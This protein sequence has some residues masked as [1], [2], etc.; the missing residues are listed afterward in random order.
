MASPYSDGGRERVAS[1]L[2]VALRQKLVTRA[3]QLGI[4]M[5]DAVTEAVEQR[6]ARPVGDNPALDTAGAE[7]WNT[8]L[9][10]GLYDDFKAGCSSRDI[11]FVQGLAEAVRVWVDSHTASLSEL[12]IPSTR[13]ASSC[14]TRR[15]ASARP[16]SPQG[17]G[18]P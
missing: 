7:S 14:A 8:W 12:T 5:Q 4:D 18:R 16:P 6:R 2:P 11:S 1:K 9:P 15:A 13:A 17:S 3:A 10:A